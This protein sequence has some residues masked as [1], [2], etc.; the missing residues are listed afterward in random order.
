MRL[1]HLSD[2]HLGYYNKSVEVNPK[3][4][5][6]GHIGLRREVTRRTFM[7]LDMA[8]DYAI[9]NDIRLVLIAGD[10][11]EDVD[12]SLLYSKR[13]AEA[14]ERL[15]KNRIYTIVIAGNH[16]AQVRRMKRASLAIFTRELSQYIRYVDVYSVAN[17]VE[18][19]NKGG[20]TIEI[21]ELDV[22]VIPL[23]YVYPG[24]GWTGAV[25]R[26][27]ERSASRAKNRYKVLLGH[28]QVD[29]VRFS[30]MYE[31][32]SEEMVKIGVLTL[33]DIRHDLFDYVALGHI[34]LMQRV[35]SENVYYSGSLNRLRFDEALDE[36]YFLDVKL[37]PH[38]KV[39]PVSV[40]PIKM[41][42]ISDPKDL[43][44]DSLNSADEVI[45]KVSNVA[46]DLDG[47]LVKIRIYYSE[48][49][50]Y[51]KLGDAIRK[52]LKEYLFEQGVYGYRVEFRYTGEPSSLDLKE[53]IEVSE[54]NYKAALKNY[55]D[56]R[57]SDR[58]DKYR[59]RLYKEALKYFEEVE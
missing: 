39:K 36:K 59:E 45:D 19:S 51:K 29:R 35:V 48:K 54:I 42:Y 31:R 21:D 9:E 1:I 44:L 52:A 57:F 38:L 32:D 24:E 7:N 40:E 53:G 49:D 50:R 28:V 58:P 26:Y 27:V 6:G 20:Y 2:L 41:Y 37:D 34:H 33:T 22:S 56:F 13:F 10:I 18:L 5:V 47:A 55:I 3:K 8:I 14:L 30:K 15:V 12:S 11:F 46:T 4:V 25:R 43:D 23:P 17:L 16:D